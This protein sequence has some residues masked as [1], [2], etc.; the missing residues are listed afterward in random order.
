MGV[1]Q[2]NVD[3]LKEKINIL[4][5]RLSL[6]PVFAYASGAAY[7][8]CRGTCMGGCSGSCVASCDSTCTGIQ[9]D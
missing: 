3:E 1:F 6:E 2:I 8:D 4:E 7:Y 5:R 9:T